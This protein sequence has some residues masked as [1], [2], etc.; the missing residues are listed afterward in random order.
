MKIK[1]VE[2][3]VKTVLENEPDT[4]NDDF[5]LITSVYYAINPETI[6]MNFGQIMYLHRELNLPSFE[7]VTRGRRRIQAENDEL[8]PEEEIIKK[9]KEKE[10]EYYEY[11]LKRKY[12]VIGE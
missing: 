3:I 11:A 8:K 2:K 5:K 6:N 7:S 10:S 9:R 12:S 1:N 4:R